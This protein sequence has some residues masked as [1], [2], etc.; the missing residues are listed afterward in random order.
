MSAGGS[1]SVMADELP[2]KALQLLNSPDY[3]F[4]QKFLTDMEESQ[5]KM[6]LYEYCVENHPYE[7]FLKLS[8]HLLHSPGNTLEIKSKCADLIH[9]LLD[10]PSDSCSIWRSSTDIVKDQL[11]SRILDILEGDNP[12]NV[13]ELMWKT[14]S[15][16][17][18]CIIAEKQGEWQG[19]LRFFFDSLF[20]G[21]LYIQDCALS[22]FL[23][24]PKCMGNELR[25]YFPQLKS[26]LSKKFYKSK[27]MSKVLALC[28]LVNLVQHM[29]I[30]YYSQFSDLLLPMING[31][32]HFLGNKDE[33]PHAQESLKKLVE[34]VVTEPSFFN[35]HLDEVFTALIKISKDK[36]FEEETRCLAVEVMYAFDDNSIKKVR[37]GIVLAELGDELIRMVSCIP[38]K[39]G[40]YLVGEKFLHRIAILQSAEFHIP[41]VLEQIERFTTSLNWRDRYAGAT[42][43]GLITEGC[44][45]GISDNRGGVVKLVFKLIADSENNVCFAT[46]RTIKTL[47]EQLPPQTLD[48]QVYIIITSLL[49]TLVRDTNPINKA[50]TVCTIS[51]LCKSCSSSYLAPYLQIIVNALLEIIKS[52][53]S[54]IELL[55]AHSLEALAS[56][57]RTSKDL[58]CTFYESVITSLKELLPKATSNSVKGNAVEC[59][60][61]VAVVVGKDIFKKDANEVKDILLNIGRNLREDDHSL[62]VTLLQAWEQLIICLGYDFC[63]DDLMPGLLRAASL[64]L[65]NATEHD[66]LRVKLRACELLLCLTS[67]FNNEFHKWIDMVSDILVPLVTFRDKDIRKVAISAMPELLISAKHSIETKLDPPSRNSYL[68]RLLLQ[69]VPSLV[70]A[71][72]KEADGEVCARIVKSLTKCI[73]SAGKCLDKE[74]ILRTANVVE[75]VLKATLDDQFSE[76]E[77]VTE[78]EKHIVDEIVNYYHKLVKIYDESSWTIIIRFME[79]QIALMRNAATEKQKQIVRL[80]FK[81]EP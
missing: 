23:D 1:S 52:Q 19:M 26:T 45:K 4:I 51:T 24:L 8:E 54:E 39:S 43:I 76:E 42:F 66:M 28:A 68:K 59:I 74:K 25:H 7:L 48:D 11:K 75:K 21:P 67:P 17:F 41:A 70:E 73:E 49:T 12:V 64:D 65:N 53:S 57:A 34:L 5:D 31:V 79:Y 18:S 30:D 72:E 36:S 77:N 27:G 40:N 29:S 2:Q 37:K 60:W 81:N 3:Y 80:T 44:G 71:L 46:V 50:H 16:I 69:I 35:S 20:S 6:T 33:E 10:S 58:F 32:S 78:Q 22:F 63:P 56:V 13:C 55:Q 15:Q 47:C 62:K 38:H 14:A 9:S 61:T